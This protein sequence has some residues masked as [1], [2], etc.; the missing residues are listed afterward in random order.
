MEINRNNYEVFFIDY[1]DGNLSD[2]SIKDLF[3]FLDNNND[4]KLEFENFSIITLDNENVILEQKDLLKEIT[5]ETKLESENFEKFCI[6][7]IENDLTKNQI[8]VFD[9]YKKSAEQIKTLEFYKKTKLVSDNSIVF[10]SKNSIKRT[11][12]FNIKY[13][14]FIQATYYSVAASILL[15]IVFSFLN[16]NNILKNYNNRI[17]AEKIHSNEID[18]YY[19]NY[20]KDKKGIVQ[21]NN[22]VQKAST[23]KSKKRI[24][25]IN[26]IETPSLIIDINLPEIANNEA[27]IDFVPNK[28]QDEQK[29]IE[30]TQSNKNNSLMAF[31]KNQFS[32]ILKSNNFPVEADFDEDSKLS[33]LAFNSKI[34]KVEH[35]FAK[36]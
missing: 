3:L 6:A 25:E 8:K 33:R 16:Q 35:I 12:I 13:K 14:T 1:F 26:K 19:D 5:P 20:N 4:L 9:S 10:E 7:F 11:S 27:E 17:T 30:I 18:T 36:N 34:I 21:E 24:K 22:S 15:F 32:K 2:N 31:A 29:S 28:G 23:F